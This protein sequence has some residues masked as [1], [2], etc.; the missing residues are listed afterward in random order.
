MHGLEKIG[1]AQIRK[2]L[3]EK[4]KVKDP[5]ILGQ[6]KRKLV[7]LIIW[8]QKEEAKG[9]PLN[10]LPLDTEDDEDLLNEAKPEEEMATVAEE[11]V[12][13]AQPSFESDG[14]IDYVMR[15]FRDYELIEGHPTCHGCRRVVQKLIGPIQSAGV[16]TIV[17]P[18]Q[19]N[20]GT[21]TV[22]FQVEVRIQNESHPAFGYRQNIMISDVADVNKFNTDPP[23]HKYSS[24]S[25]ATRAEGRVYRKVLGLRGMV[26]EEI[27]EAATKNDDE[28]V[29]DTLITEGQ[30]GII[31]MMCKPERC[32][33]HV[34]EFVNIGEKQYTTIE[35]VPKATAVKM[36][37][38]LNAIQQEVDPRPKGVGQYDPEWRS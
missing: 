16:Q 32:N 28:W 10:N 31:A 11:D 36:I 1:V 8:Y 37:Q 13:E 4:Y 9:Q 15:Q 27:S 35:S 30:V 26:H 12:P 7:E 14:W 23:Y 18:T 2:D 20:F 6:S 29:E 25:A 34:M 22:V 38:K 5:E 21:S 19:E 17:A 33:L 3:K 24:A